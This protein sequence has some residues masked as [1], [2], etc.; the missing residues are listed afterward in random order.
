[1]FLGGLKEYTLLVIFLVCK[2]RRGGGAREKKVLGGD[3]VVLF[4]GITA[5]VLL[6]LKKHVAN[7][8]F[9]P[10]LWGQGYNV[11]LETGESL[12]RRSIVTT[13][14]TIKL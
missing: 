11:T 2:G 4:P 9:F 12:I 1:M 13:P 14:P 7:N 6:G 5:E 10:E 3:L 8:P